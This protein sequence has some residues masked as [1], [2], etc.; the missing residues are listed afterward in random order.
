M[1]EPRPLPNTTLTRGPQ[2]AL[3]Q[4][5]VW[6]LFCSVV[7]LP[8]LN[9]PGPT[10][11]QV[12]RWLIGWAST[13]LLISM[14]LGGLYVR[15]PER[16]MQGLRV[17]P[18]I[19][20]GCVLAGGF[21]A[22]AQQVLVPIVGREPWA[23]ARV[24]DNEQLF[25]STV[26]GFFLFSLWSGAFLANL[27]STRVQEE[28]ERSARVQ[29]LAD[30]AQLQVLRSQ[31]NPHFLFN[32]LNSVVGLISENPKG[33][34]RMVRDVSSLLRQ[35]LD[36]DARR[37]TTVEQELDFVRLY[38]KC[39][40]VRF[41]ARLQ[42]TFEVADDAKALLMPA[43]VLQ[44]LVEN[45]LKHGLH[46]AVTTALQ[47]RISAR[48]DGAMLVLEVANSGSLTAPR[49]AV[50]PAPSG[51]GLTNLKGRLAH[52]FPGAHS[53]ELTERD[54]WVFATLRLPARTAPTGVA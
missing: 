38:V 53:F 37:E 4:A 11:A 8:S 50:L 2:F 19:V 47:V 16:L 12:A 20:I 7:V 46:A 28:V 30:Q 31:I 18:M 24:T 17:I 33:A 40:E 39:E 5:V 48:R 45:A 1:G 36:T 43:M 9:F 32:A 26:R 14:A 13:G 29:A 21:W 51:I 35:A 6:A 22:L 41:E 23:P 27:L 25:F 49:D 3:F 54:G 10:F 44:P 15:V 34:Q 42:A 52:Q